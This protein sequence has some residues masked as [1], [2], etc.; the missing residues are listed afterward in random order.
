[1]VTCDPAPGM[2]ADV[3]R[4]A[5]DL[6]FADSSFDVVSCRPRRITS[7]RRRRPSPRWRV[8][9]ARVLLVDTLYMGEAAEQ[10][11]KPR[12]PSHVRNYSLEDGAP[13][14][15]LPGSSSRRKWRSRT[16]STSPRG[17]SAQGARVGRLRVRE[18]WGDRVA[19]ERLT[20]DKVALKGR[21]SADG[22]PRRHG[23]R[24]VVQGLTG[25]EGRFHGLRNRAYGTQVVAGVT[26]GKGGQDVEGIP[27]YDTVAGGG[28]AAGR[29]HGHG[30]RAGARSPPT[31]STR[32][33]TPGSTP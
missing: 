29:Q 12:D 10:A 20:L 7:P 14:S 3:I 4:R 15:P 33:S 31:R 30:L 2:G 1:M 23:T 24:L 8:S 17:S 13:F 32:G 16:R 26:P 27:V 28:R 22:D 18:L 25:S 11:E 21:R 19:G 5:E 6:P 9:R